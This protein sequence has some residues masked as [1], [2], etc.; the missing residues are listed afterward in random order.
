MLEFYSIIKEHHYDR[1]ALTILSAFAITYFLIPQLVKVSFVRKLF[2]TPNERKSAIR[3][4]VPTLGGVAI[5][6]GTTIS[7]LIVNPNSL[8]SE[9]FS[10]LGISIAIVVIGLKDDLIG[11]FA[12]NKLF[13]EL[14]II[15]YV[16]VVMNLRILNFNGFLGLYEA[17]YFL[18]IV[19]TF[20]FSIGLINSLNLIDGIDGLFGSTSLLISLVFGCL[21]LTSN[22]Q[23]YS[24]LNFSL[25]GSLMAFLLFNIF[26][27]TNK[28]FSGDTGTLFVG[29]ILTITAVKSINIDLVSISTIISLFA[30]PIFDTIHVFFIRINSK[31]SPFSPDMNHTHHI[32]LKYGLSHL[33][34]TLILISFSLICI[35]SVKYLPINPT[36]ILLGLFFIYV[37]ASYSLNKWHSV[38]TTKNYE[39]ETIQMP[40]LDLLELHYALGLKRNPF[41][42]FSAEEEIDY[43]D[44][45][46]LNPKYFQPLFSDIKKGHTRFILGARGV[47]KTAL[48]IKLK[49]QLDKNNVFSII[50]DD[51]EGIPTEN[52]GKYFL[53]NTIRKIVTRYCSAIV[54]SPMLLKK[55]KKSEKERLTFFIE[56]FFNPITK[57]EFEKYVNIASNYKSR[58]YWI[59]GCNYLLRPF[60]SILS[61]GIEI[62]GDVIKKSFGLDSLNTTMVYKDYVKEFKEYIPG[63]T[64]F[65]EGDNYSLYKDI[66]CDLTSIIK[67]SGFEEVVIIYDKIDEFKKLGGDIFKINEFLNDVLTDTNLLLN[68]DFGFVFSLWSELK[69]DLSKI[70]V[71]FDKIS[72]IDVTWNNKEL[73]DIINVRLNHFRSKPQSVIKLDDI[74]AD[75]K[76]LDEVISISNKS[77]RDLLRLI[78]SIYYEQANIDTRSHYLSIVAIRKGILKFISEYDYYSIFP[79]SKTKNDILINLNLILSCG[80]LT[81]KILDLTQDLNISTQTANGLLKNLQKYGIIKELNQIKSSSKLYDI[82]DPKIVWLIKN[83]IN[84][85][86]Y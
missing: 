61:L 75:P 83:Q 4:V 56:N 14:G 30:L 78:S 28:I 9:I 10:I 47:G 15:T 26:G 67:K 20:V 18:S 52:N 48:I 19:F 62:G 6:T 69:S 37:F 68:R 41:S 70:G 79:Q 45:V 58:N 57:N 40:K 8:I 22:N 7:L 65:I 33:K 36:L 81:F 76:S 12:R 51:Y 86:G 44:E 34:S 21:F 60:N 73:E 50:I 17:D 82:I 77:P 3:R 11:I 55:L 1:I 23:S 80:K 13:F 74:L 84:P 42:R 35:I 53:E 72:P 5:F 39:K 32:L 66:I 27:K 49:K 71:R 2:D 64:I 31:R 16:I 24:L 25:A 29:F 59:K 38:K 85:W 63:K 43:L 54:N 46:Y